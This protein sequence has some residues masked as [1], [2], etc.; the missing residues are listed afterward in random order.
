MVMADVVTL[1]EAVDRRGP[2]AVWDLM[3]EEEQ[4]EAAAALWQNADR[5]SRALIE[6]SLAKDLRFRAKS[7]RRLSAERVVG[8]LVRLVEELPDNVVFQFLF[9]LHMAARRELLAQFLDG[10]GLPHENGVLDL[11]EGAEAPDAETINKAAGELLG[12][13]DHQGLVYLAT[14]KVA[15]DEF[16]AGVDGVLEGYSEDGSPIES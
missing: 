5:E 13:H 7:V 15:D 10:V 14:L 16:W 3:S 2:Y 1:K 8:R 4:R 6:L 11:P 12:T 9:H